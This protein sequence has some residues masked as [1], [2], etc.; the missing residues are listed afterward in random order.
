MV[1]V[2]VPA[3][4]VPEN[5]TSPATI[6]MGASVVEMDVEEA[7]VTLLAVFPKVMVTPLVPVTLPFS[8]ILPVAFICRTTVFPD[9]GLDVV[10]L[11]FVLIMVNAPLVDVTEPEVPKVVTEPV[12]VKSPPTDEVPIIKLD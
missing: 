8:V 5:A 4:T 3:L 2:P 1:T 7:L 6:V 12:I 11:E 9:I 10:M